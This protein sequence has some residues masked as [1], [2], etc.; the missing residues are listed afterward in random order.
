[1]NKQF[2]YYRPKAVDMRKLYIT[3]QPTPNKDIRFDTLDE[4]SLDNLWLDKSRRLQARRWR[5]IKRQLV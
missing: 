2:T 5:K 4:D 3:A 1:M